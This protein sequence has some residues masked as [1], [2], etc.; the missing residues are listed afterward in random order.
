M[1]DDTTCERRGKGKEEMTW[2]C[3]IV[4]DGIWGRFLCHPGSPFVERVLFMRV[5]R[6]RR[7]CIWYNGGGYENGGDPSKEERHNQI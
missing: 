7:V 5:K 3:E 2:L 1:S 4:G 6:L